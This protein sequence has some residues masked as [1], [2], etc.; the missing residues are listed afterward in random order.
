MKTAQNVAGNPSREPHDGFTLIELLV[1]IAIIAILAGM[2]LPALSKAKAK[3]KQAAC[4]SNMR[5]IGLAIQL[6]ADDHDGWMPTTTHGLGASQ[7]NRSWIFT[8]R[9]YVGNVDSIRICPADPKG[10]QRMTNNASSYVMNEYTAVD[11]IDPFGRLLESFRNLNRLRSPSSTHT[12]FICSDKYSP[13]V[14]ADH[15]HSRNWLKG[16]G[17]VLEDIEPDRHRAGAANASHTSGS[18]N[19]LFADTHVEVIKAT[20]LKGR[21]DRGED[22]ARPAQ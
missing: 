15:V 3:G 10:R 6:Y 9:G 17:A 18:A 22:F 19:Y 5:Q 2:L 4:S 13:S 12:V 7:T 1:V 11:R 20:T 8:L 14:F 16:W 21:V